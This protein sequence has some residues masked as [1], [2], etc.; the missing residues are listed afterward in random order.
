M[1]DLG[2]RQIAQETIPEHCR[3]K[4]NGQW[5]SMISSFEMVSYVVAAILSGELFLLSFAMFCHCVLFF[6]YL[7]SCLFLGFI[8][9]LLMYGRLSISNLF[10]HSTR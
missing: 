7:R 8:G 4:V 10:I 9:Y 3:G 1:F 2:V 5:K 6:S